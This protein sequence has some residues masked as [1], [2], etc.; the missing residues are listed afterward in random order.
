L[1]SDELTFSLPELYRE[2]ANKKCELMS[3]MGQRQTIIHGNEK[4]ASR[5]SETHWR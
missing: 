2:V 4:S 3:H 5:Q 1:A